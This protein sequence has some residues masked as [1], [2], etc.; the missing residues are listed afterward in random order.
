MA[1]T[2]T[3]KIF[4]GMLKDAD[5]Y[6]QRPTDADQL[7]QNAWLRAEKHHG[8]LA[9]VFSDFTTFLRLVQSWARGRYRQAPWKT[10]AMVLGAILYFMSP[11]D[12][13]P[14]IIPV[15]GFMD[16]AFIIAWVMRSVRKDVQRFREWEEAGAF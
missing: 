14:D 10:I 6:K 13:I 4:G 12:A 16:D 8:P 7:A 11:I 2:R 1:W 15:L 5:S 3:L 9:R